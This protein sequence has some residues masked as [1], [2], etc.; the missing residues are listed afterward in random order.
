ML[1]GPVKVLHIHRTEIAVET[2]PIP[3]KNKSYVSSAAK[4]FE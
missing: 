2:R 3:V 1:Y 4:K